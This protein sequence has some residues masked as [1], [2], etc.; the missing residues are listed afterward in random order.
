M[1]YYLEILLSQEHPKSIF[2]KENQKIIEIK[3]KTENLKEFK[4]FATLAEI[5]DPLKNLIS[6]DEDG[7]EGFSLGLFSLNENSNSVVGMPVIASCLDDY[8][9]DK[10]SGELE[11]SS[12]KKIR[13]DDKL[14]KSLEKSISMIN[15]FNK[16]IDFQGKLIFEKLYYDLRFSMQNKLS[17]KLL[18]D[19]DNKEN[20]QIFG[21]YLEY[22]G[23][24][25]IIEE[26][27]ETTNKFFKENEITKILLKGERFIGKI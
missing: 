17:P 14:I 15:S 3:R 9:L 23:L 25:I 4:N 21:E 7:D 11:I 19:K 10:K 26:F 27:F 13:E 1:S 16:N 18:E 20:Q 8:C 24:S 22:D 6:Q 12:N 2:S 5:V